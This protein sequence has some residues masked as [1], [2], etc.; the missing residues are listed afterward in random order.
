MD[1]SRVLGSALDPRKNHEISCNT[2]EN[3]GVLK[4]LTKKI[5]A[6]PVRTLAKELNSKVKNIKKATPLASGNL[7]LEFVSQEALV[8]SI[9]LGK[10]KLNSILCVV[11]NM[12]GE[13]TYDVV[14]HGISMEE[15]LSTLQHRLDFDRSKGASL[16]AVDRLPNKKREPSTALKLTFA[17]ACPL[18]VYLRE[19]DLTIKYK[20]ETYVK[21][22]T[23]CYLCQG[24]GH[25]A[26]SC[27]GSIRCGRCAGDHN[28]RDDQK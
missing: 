2:S 14:I 9:K 20:T 3:I 4:G 27:R 10:F 16:V 15:D 26:K 24:F 21:P 11:T 6:L 1:L 13:T 25:M 19:E 8:T 5:T 18:E 12:P 23:R 28:T 17:G 7:L 22:P